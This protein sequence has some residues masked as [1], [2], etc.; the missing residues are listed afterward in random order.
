VPGLVGA[1]PILLLEHGEL[2]LGNDLT[3]PA[4]D[5][6]ADDPRSDHTDTSHSSHKN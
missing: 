4:R 2:G 6:Q 5:R 1:N 3:Q